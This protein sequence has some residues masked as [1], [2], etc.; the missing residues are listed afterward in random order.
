[1]GERVRSDLETT[2]KICDALM[3]VLWTLHELEVITDPAVSAEATDN[4][5]A[6]TVEFLLG[7]D[8]KVEQGV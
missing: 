1:M 7:F 8:R 6:V 4:G 2:E 5:T 3:S